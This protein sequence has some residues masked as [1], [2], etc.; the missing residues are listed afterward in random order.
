MR[1]EL[2]TEDGGGIKQRDTAV[3]DQIGAIGVRKEARGAQWVAI[4]VPGLRIVSV[5][6]NSVLAVVRR[7][8]QVNRRMI[9]VARVGYRPCQPCKNEHERQRH[10]PKSSPC[11]FQVPHGPIAQTTEFCLYASAVWPHQGA[12]PTCGKLPFARFNRIDAFR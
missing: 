6:T 7:V 8:V 3:A 10:T 1:R 11:P 4:A 9:A 12:H 2:G 5:V